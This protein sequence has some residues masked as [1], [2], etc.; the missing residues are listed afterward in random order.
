VAKAWKRTGPPDSACALGGGAAA[1][2][3]LLPFSP[4]NLGIIRK[5]PRRQ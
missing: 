4:E 1:A 5:P 2:L 3:R